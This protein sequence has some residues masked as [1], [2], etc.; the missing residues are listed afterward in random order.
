MNHKGVESDEVFHTGGR[1]FVVSLAGGEALLTQNFFQV[2]V[3][4]KLF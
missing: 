3:V 1:D 4:S 2:S